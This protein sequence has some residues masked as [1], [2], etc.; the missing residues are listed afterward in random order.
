M[1]SRLIGW[2]GRW[3]QRDD[4]HLVKRVAPETADPIEELLCIVCEAQERDAADE[5]RLYP[6]RSGRPS[7]YRQRRLDRR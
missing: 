1:M 5:R 7:S 4:Q 6:W 2:L 3:R